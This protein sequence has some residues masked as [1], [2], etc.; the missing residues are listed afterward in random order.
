MKITLHT[1]PIREV[2]EG[3]ENNEEQGVVGYGGKLNIRPPYQREMVYSEKQEQAVIN[4][5]FHQFP[6]NV[7]YWVKNA[8]GT[9]E[10]LDGQQRT[11]SICNYCAGEYFTIVDGSLK[12]YDNLSATQRERFLEYQLQVYVCEEA[13]DEEK[14]EWFRIINIAGEKLTDQELLNAI[15]AGPWL[16]HAKPRFSKTRCVAASLGEKYLSGSPIRQDY[17]RTVIDWISGGKI[18][19]YM[20]AHQYDATSDREWQYFQQVIQWVQSLFPTYRKEMKGLSWGVLYNR[21]HEQFYSATELENRVS[22]LMEDEDVTNKK[23]I[24]EYVLG[25]EE[26]CL[27]IRAFSDKMKREVYERQ[28][29]ICVHCEQHFDLSAMEADHI[30]PWHEGGTTTADNCQ[31]LCKQCNRRKGGK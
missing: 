18:Q 30:T 31:M 17:L 4:S 24:Y 7:F 3:F 2:V 25:G 28:H 6:L 20:A 9:Y 5:V 15:Y 11:L 13:T 19:E 10:M 12:C 29:G 1:V 21:Y 14:L 23:G 16:S 8:D 26:R 27:N 22:S